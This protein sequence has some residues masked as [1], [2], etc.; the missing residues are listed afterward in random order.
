M[1]TLTFDKN[2][3]RLD[4]FK[5]VIEAKFKE[6]VAKVQAKIP[7]DNV[8]VV[9][10][11]KPE[12]T[13]LETG[14][15]GYAYNAYN[16][17]IYL[18]PDFPNFK[19]AVLGDNL[20][21]VLAHELHHC[22]RWADPGYGETLL[23]HI[24][25]EGLADHFEVEVNGGKP[26]IWAV[27]LTPEQISEWL[28]KAKPLFSSKDFDRNAWM[29]GSAE[30]DMPKSIGYSLGFHL[31]GEYLKQHPTEKASTLYNKKAEA[32]ML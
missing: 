13:I 8:S 12:H 5:E 2:S 17:E 1:I 31:V 22:L 28:E 20:E 15:G 24:I 18:N 19:E 4:P 14:E 9:M 6:S 27:R 32:F 3:K 23:E 25:S 26:G 16:L 21:R 10:L 11:D 7:V 29:F 30:K